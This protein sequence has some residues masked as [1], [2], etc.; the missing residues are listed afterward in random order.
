MK[1]HVTNKNAQQKFKQYF[2][3]K[4]SGLQIFKDYWYTFGTAMIHN[5]ILMVR[6]STNIFSVNARL[7]FNFQY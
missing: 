5:M 1:Y 4:K 3:F 2:S 7:D 6:N